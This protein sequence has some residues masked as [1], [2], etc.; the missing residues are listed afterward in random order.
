MSYS[1]VQR[2]N[3]TST[4]TTLSAATTAGTTLLIYIISNSSTVPTVTTNGVSVP[5][6]CGYWSNG[7]GNTWCGIFYVRGM[8]NPGGI[9]G[10]TTSGIYSSYYREVSGIPSNPVVNWN[11]GGNS[12]NG[13]TFTFSVAG[14]SVAGDFITDVLAYNTNN[15]GTAR[16]D[17]WSDL[18][19]ASNFGQTSYNITSTT[20]GSGTLSSSGTYDVCTLDF[21]QIDNV[22]PWSAIGSLQSDLPTSG[23]GSMTV[24]VSAAGNLLVLYTKVGNGTN[25]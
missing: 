6:F 5:V 17:G 23:Q 7:H 19:T 3:G 8:D 12:T 21:Q 11:F 14:V 25:F 10:W 1:V 24:T 13:T 9:T 4:T 16:T 20:G 15:S 22:G 2:G 18:Q